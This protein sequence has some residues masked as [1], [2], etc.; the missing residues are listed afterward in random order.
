MADQDYDLASLSS[1][2]VNVHATDA[3]NWQEKV[4]NQVKDASWKIHFGAGYTH[5]FTLVESGLTNDLTPAIDL[6]AAAI[7]AFL[8]VC[9]DQGMDTKVDPGLLNKDSCSSRLNEL[10]HDVRND[11][12]K[13]LKTLL[14]DSVIDQATWTDKITELMNDTF[15]LQRPNDA[16]SSSEKLNDHR[17]QENATI[18]AWEVPYQGNLHEE[19]WKHIS[20]LYAVEKKDKDQ[21][22]NMCTI[23][24]S[25]GTGKSRMVDQLCTEHFVIP[26]CLRDPK[27]NGFLPSDDKVRKYFL[28]SMEL[29]EATPRK[30]NEHY[31]IKRIDAFFQALFE[32]TKAKLDEII[33]KIYSENA[34]PPDM[35]RQASADFRQFMTKGQRYNDPGED[36]LKFYSEMIK[37]AETLA[38]S[39]ISPTTGLAKQDSLNPI[40][41]GDALA[42]QLNSLKSSPELLFIVA[43]DE[44]TMLTK[45]QDDNR[46]PPILNT[47]RNRLNYLK[48]VPFF[49]LLLSTTGH[50]AP[51][52]SPFGLPD[53]STRILEG[54]LKLNPAFTGCIF[55]AFDAEHIAFREGKM[56][57]QQAASEWT[58]M[59]LGRPLWT[60]RVDKWRVENGISGG[61]VSFGSM[62][63]S[64]QSDRDLRDSTT[65]F[66]VRRDAMRFAV[67]KLLNWTAIDHTWQINDDQMIAC[68]CHR[69]PIEFQSSSPFQ[70][71]FVENHM[72]ICLRLDPEDQTMVSMSSSEPVLSEA[73]FV[74]M[75][76]CVEKIL[77]TMKIILGG[78]SVNKGDRGELV[79]LLILLLARDEAVC[80]RNTADMWKSIR[81]REVA[82]FSSDSIENLRH[83]VEPKLIEWD[84]VFT[85]PDF[86]RA[87]FGEIEG[88]QEKIDTIFKN[89]R[90]HFNHF[91]KCFQQS[92]LQRQY[93]AALLMRGAAL[94][95]A[96]GQKAVDAAVPFSF[97]DEIDRFLIS[98]MLIQVK[99][100]PHYSYV[101]QWRV[102][103]AMDIRGLDIVDRETDYLPPVIRVVFALAASRSSVTGRIEVVKAEDGRC[104]LAVDIW[105]AGISSNILPCIQGTWKS[106]DASASW[107][108]LLA[109]SQGWKAPY[110]PPG[111]DEVKDFLRYMTPCLGDDQPFW[112]F[113]H[114]ATRKR[115]KEDGLEGRLAA[116]VESFEAPLYTEGLREPNRPF[117]GIFIRAPVITD[118]TPSALSPPV[119]II[120]R[121]SA[122]LLPRGQQIVSEDEDDTDPR[123]PRTVVALR[124][125]RHLVTTFHP[126][127]TKDDRF[128]E[129][130]VKQCVLP[131]LEE[132]K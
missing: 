92:I 79:A 41:A 65:K 105:C 55:D 124:Q 101:P 77:P 73:S 104:Y 7:A 9:V 54:H 95:C 10:E 29:D 123:D 39:V 8:S 44:S 1:T 93:L 70:Y 21:Y 2:E 99:N 40:L 42:T 85:V 28:N 51:F 16:G 38:R 62:S 114:D 78:F 36:R 66:V 96:N 76:K 61:D 81:L 46:K 52:F 115:D 119:Q 63:A 30:F 125:G 132:S 103:D 59:H 49:S 68:L 27:T 111:E 80:K 32:S 89:T 83:P 82:S 128:H 110:I 71:R 127:L 5:Y 18:A 118:I 122:S 116:M 126:E 33:N 106:S 113:C 84:R 19:L 6:L 13:R 20:R 47:L 14:V 112:K 4:F 117:N 43:F 86:L 98:A 120:S 129:F 57:V 25:S 53:G 94:L 50:I 130:F 107:N 35:Y 74:V 121:L 131:A 15:F 75:K 11:L 26:I 87:L 102:L 64:Q 48:S 17:A 90:M 100:D 97:Q 37:R 12:L 45:I 91:I 60:T 34:N 88:I 22:A 23:I 31:A 67:I 56:T 109:Y 3:I 58:M 24:Q 69:L 108:S 72:R